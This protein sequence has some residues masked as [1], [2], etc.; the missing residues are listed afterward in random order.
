MS[1]LVTKF[2]EDWMDR[3][4]RP[5]MG[6]TYMATCIFDFIIAPVLWS[7][8]QAYYGGQVTSQWQPLTLQGAGLYHMAMGAVLGVTAWT[9]GQEKMAGVAGPLVQTTTAQPQEQTAAVARPDPVTKPAF[10][11]RTVPQGEDKLL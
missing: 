7:I 9:R 8:V 11:A 3:R 10:T 4:W 1:S 2:K 5:M 6:W